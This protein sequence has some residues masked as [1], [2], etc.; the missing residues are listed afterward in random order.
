MSPVRIAMRKVV[1]LFVDGGWLAAATL[2]VIAFTGAIRFLL[3]ASPMLAGTVLVLGC[4]G[5][6]VGSVLSGLQK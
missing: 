1:G 2:G 6:L 4:L 5:V 3:P